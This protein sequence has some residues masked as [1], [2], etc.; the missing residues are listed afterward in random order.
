[1]KRFKYSIDGIEGEEFKSENL[2]SAYQKIAD[3]SGISVWEILK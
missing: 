3:R 1:M 2:D